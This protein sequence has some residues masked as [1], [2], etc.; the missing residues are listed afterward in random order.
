MLR[1]L[2]IRKAPAEDI[3]TLKQNCIHA[4]PN[5]GLLWFYY[6]ETIIDNAM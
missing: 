1:L 5:Y 2:C 4:E 6:K 3:A